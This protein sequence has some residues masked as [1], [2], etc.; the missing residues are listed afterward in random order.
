MTAR[1]VSLPEVPRT[2]PGRRPLS[3]TGR[4]LVLNS[5]AMI[6]ACLA[7]ALGPATVSTPIHERELLVL[8]AGVTATIGVNVR[9]VRR[10]F[11]PLERLT[12]LMNRVDPLAPGARLE[13]GDA[14]RE[15][16]ELTEAFNDMLGRLEHERRESRAAR[17]APKRPSAGVWRPSSTTSSARR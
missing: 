14:P 4:M 8:L 12:A 5:A 15:V 16:D 3:L 2:P 6:L 13:A 7:L 17:C 10:A 11:A 9:L 1:P